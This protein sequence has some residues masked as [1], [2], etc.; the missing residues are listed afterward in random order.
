M[1]IK[2]QQLGGVTWKVYCHVHWPNLLICRRENKAQG[3]FH[4]ILH[5]KRSRIEPK[6][7]THRSIHS[8]ILIQEK[9]I[10]LY[11]QVTVLLIV[12][13]SIS[14]RIFPFLAG[15]GVQCVLWGSLPDFHRERTYAQVPRELCSYTHSCTTDKKKL[16]TSLKKKISICKKCSGVSSGS[17]PGELLL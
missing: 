2:W 15:R 11:S 3:A 4:T 16:S 10:K 8:F 9:F 14:S 17:V 7:Q 5:S 1:P 13:G 12:Q 6:F